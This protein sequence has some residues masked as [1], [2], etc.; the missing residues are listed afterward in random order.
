LAAVWVLPLLLL[1]VLR[2]S[3]P[4]EAW[5]SKSMELSAVLLPSNRGLKGRCPGRPAD[6]NG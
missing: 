4:R 3:P 1:M 6:R 5:L 2:G